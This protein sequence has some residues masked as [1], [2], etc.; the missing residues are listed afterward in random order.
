MNFFFSNIRLSSSKVAIEKN[1]RRCTG[2]RVSTDELIEEAK[3]TLQKVNTVSYGTEG[4]YAA[5]IN[6]IKNDINSLSTGPI[7]FLEQNKKAEDALKEVNMNSELKQILERKKRFLDAFEGSLAAIKE[8]ATNYLRN[9]VS[10]QI[11][12][13][14]KLIDDIY[15]KIVVHPVFQH[16]S[17]DI[18]SRDPLIYAI[19][20][21]ENG[22]PTSA[23]TRFSMAQL[24]TFALSIL[25]ANNIKLSFSN[26]FSILIMDD[27]TQVMDSQHKEALSKLIAEIGKDKQI[28]IS[29][30]DEE[31]KSGLERNC[32]TNLSTIEFRDWSKEGPVIVCNNSYSQDKKSRIKT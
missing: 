10:N 13:H 32:K 29:T 22:D 26:P 1:L 9:E 19:K 12:K 17:V 27:P 25:I 3:M 31:F 8:V 24:N 28:I 18:Q 11:G 30:A 16:V 6:D 21:T 5:K 20:I 14:G 23:T 15:N 4:E 2:S 7:S